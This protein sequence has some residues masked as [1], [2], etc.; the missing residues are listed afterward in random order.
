MQRFLKLPEVMRVTGL[1]RSSIYAFIQSNKFPAP[2]PLGPRA[3]GWLE[4][5]VNDWVQQKIELRGS[6]V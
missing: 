4:A 2:I 6:N 5:E 1:S 3:V